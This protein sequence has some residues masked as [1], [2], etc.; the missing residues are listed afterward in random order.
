MPTPIIISTAGVTG[1]D[2]VTP[3]YEPNARWCWWEISEI[4]VGSLGNKRYVPKIGDYVMDK[5]IY[6]VYKVEDIDPVTLIADLRAVTQT[7]SGSMTDDDILFGVGPGTQADTYRVY[8]DTSVL[9]YVLAVDARLKVGGSASSYAR[10][11]KGSD[12]SNTLNLVSA[13][14]DQSG[15]L[16]T[17]N[18]P[19][20]AAA[21]DSHTNNSIKIVSVCHTR[22]ALEDGE[23]V[24]CVIY[25]D[26]GHVVSKRQLLVEN[27]AFIRSINAA[28]KYITG[29]SIQTPFL[30]STT[31]SLI[32][33]PVNV[34][35]AGI[36]LFGIV[37]YSDGSS[38]KMP[39][40]GTKF[41]IFGLEQYL[42]TVVGQRVGLVLSYTVGAGEVVYGAVNVNDKKFVTKSLT[43]L[44]LEQDGAYAVKLFGYP[45]WQGTVSGYKMN[46][47]LYTLDR[48]VSYNVTELVKFNPQTG[49]FNPKAYG[50][51]QNLSVSINL[52]DINGSFKS[53]I[54]A[55]TI[56][57]TLL[58][59]GDARTTNWTIG[60]DALQNP[61]YGTGLRATVNYINANLNIVRVDSGIATFEEWLEKTYFA[62][63]PITNTTKELNP[64][65]PNF[66]IVK[67]GPVSAEFSITSWNSNLQVG[68]GIVTN[69]TMFLEF[70][71][72]TPSADVKLGIAG[73]PIYNV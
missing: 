45:V 33:F 5:E 51:L 40:D 10:I 28:Q 11:F 3:V 55:Q 64:P 38:I 70:I 49:P 35:L 72:R 12:V 48:D 61:P 30:S 54:H 63:R 6:A 8:L 20:E 67:N 25:N 41:K 50:F 53:Y 27:T 71:H 68:F 56:A 17:L 42:G 32:E 46:W 44:A 34:P 37:N 26:V 31:D 21:I 69:D 62:T 9:P 60:F 57:I 22:E 14:F 29:L 24:T 66:F 16:L 59:P 39:V 18:I 13:L 43:L 19:L 47:F 2:G 58:E 52:R 1:T 15:T 7:L 4:Y 23:L 73:L 36:D 65:K